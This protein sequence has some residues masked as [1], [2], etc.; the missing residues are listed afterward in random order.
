MKKGYFH[1][2]LVPLVLI[3]IGGFFALGIC[4]LLYLFIYNFVEFRFFPNNPTEVPADII[5]RAYALTLV[6]IYL[7][8]LRIKM[9]DIIKAILLVGPMGIFVTTTILTFY[10]KPAL[11]IGVTVVIVALSIFFVYKY[12][13]PWFY[14]YAIM[15]TI[16][17]SIA[18]A[19]P[20]A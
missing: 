6:I 7:A 19:W 1:S 10:E 9:A 12:K 8:L 17:A 11:V 2:V 20:E 15:A 18:L 16:L 4:Y 5:R 14:Y 3:P 13:K